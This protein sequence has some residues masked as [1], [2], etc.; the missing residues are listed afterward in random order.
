MNK[1]QELLVLNMKNARQRFGYSQ[2]K[3]AEVCN[4]ST[5]FIAEIESGKKFP[6]SSSILKI[7]EA[8][9]LKPYQLFLEKEEGS[10]VDKYKTLTELYKELKSVING[11][12]ERTVKK[13][14]SQ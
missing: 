10:A 6:S 14:M 5:S 13:Y 12:L 3:L 7:S 8:L 9:G 4:L 1:V 2:M 11:D